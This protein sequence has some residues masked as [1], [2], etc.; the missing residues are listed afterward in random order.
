MTIFD[1]LFFNSFNLYKKG[2]L[3]KHAT[4]IAVYY[5]TIVQSL[6]L[7]ALGAFF[8]EFFR[9]MQVSTMNSTRA[10]SLFALAVM[11]LY[12]KNWIQYSGKKRKVMN[13]QQRKQTSYTKT[14]LWTIPGVILIVAILFLKIF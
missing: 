14:V 1:Q 5:I 3:K 6:L 2:S 12:F 7:L 9:Q 11:V 13:A 4:T 8:A 10:W